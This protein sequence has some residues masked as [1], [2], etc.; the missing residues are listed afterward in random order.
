LG[1]PRCRSRGCAGANPEDSRPR[2]DHRRRSGE[3]VLVIVL[4]RVGV[5]GRD[6]PV[7]TR[8]TAARL[9]QWLCLH[10]RLDVMFTTEGSTIFATDTKPETSVAGRES[11][12]ESRR[13]DLIASRAH[14]TGDHRADELL[15]TQGE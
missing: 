2:P 6:L 3:E 12:A 14:R 5:L 8:L 11:K 15:P 10:H 7:R 4:I 9:R 13:C 1:Q